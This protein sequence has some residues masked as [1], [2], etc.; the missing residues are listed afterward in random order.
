MQYNIFKLLFCTVQGPQPKDIK[1][2]KAASPFCSPI[3]SW[4]SSELIAHFESK[5]WQR[6][7]RRLFA[8]QGF[9]QTGNEEVFKCQKQLSHTLIVKF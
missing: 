2:R 9:V 5:F 7:L 4:I 3:Y 8:E 6:N 1:E